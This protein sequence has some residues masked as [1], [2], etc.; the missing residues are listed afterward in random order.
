[1]SIS[2]LAEAIDDA[3]SRPEENVEMGHRA[4]Q[5]MS[6]F[7]YDSQLQAVA[8]LLQRTDSRALRGRGLPV[9]E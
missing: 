8:A 5:V 4:M 1:V 2:E 3:I 9:T 6:D 7:V